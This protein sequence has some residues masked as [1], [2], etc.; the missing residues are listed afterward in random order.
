[1]L[2]NK[3]T[4]SIASI[5]SSGFEAHHISHYFY[6]Q[7]MRS[8]SQEKERVE[9]K[10]FPKLSIFVDCASHLILGALGS[11]GPHPDVGELERNLAALSKKITLKTLIAD[12]GYDSEA[13][14][15]RLRSRGIRSLIPPWHGRRSSKAPR[16]KWRRRM[17]HQFKNKSPKLYGK[18]W[19]IETTFSMLKRNLSCALAARSFY[20]QRREL[21]LKVLTHNAMVIMAFRQLFYKAKVVPRNR[22]KGDDWRWCFITIC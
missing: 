3:R 8:Y 7:R 6:R 13:N 22:V 9:R 12:A 18:R 4:V 14:H 19:Q 10:Y 1:M 21:L 20:S 17:F 2:G 5:D 16:G 11:Q 15:E